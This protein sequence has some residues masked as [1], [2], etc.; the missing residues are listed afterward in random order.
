MQ[1]NFTYDFE[2]RYWVEYGEYC[3]GGYYFDGTNATIVYG[4]KVLKSYFQKFI[5]KQGRILDII[6]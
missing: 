6:S 4:E 3:N 5:M 1:N 2:G